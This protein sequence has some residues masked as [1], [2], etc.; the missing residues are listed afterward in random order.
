MGEALACLVEDLVRGIAK[1]AGRGTI[2]F[3]ERGVDL[4]SP[5]LPLAPSKSVLGLV[6]ISGV[7]MFCLPGE[8]SAA[9]GLELKRRFPGAWVLGAANDH[10]GTLLTDEEYQKGGGERNVSF[11]GPKMGSWLVEQ[12]T[13]LGERGHAKDRAAQPE[14]GRGKDDDRR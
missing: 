11:Y 1:S 6:E 2:S 14:G 10:L 3:V 13:K 12:F 4:P 8:A 5:T 7:R 9:L